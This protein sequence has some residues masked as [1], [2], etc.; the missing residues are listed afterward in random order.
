M[1]FLPNHLIEKN[2]EMS[3]FD[4]QTVSILGSKSATK[5]ADIS[6]IGAPL[7]LNPSAFNCAIGTSIGRKLVGMLA[8]GQFLNL[9]FAKL[10]SISFVMKF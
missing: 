3:L 9:Y 5:I 7:L 10:N 4:L 1:Y 6:T 2:E 8:S